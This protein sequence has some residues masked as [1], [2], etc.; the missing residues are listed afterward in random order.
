MTI[1]K[2]QMVANKVDVGIGDISSVMWIGGASML[3]G[4]VLAVMLYGTRD[5]EYE[6]LPIAGANEI[7]EEDV[8]MS[9]DCWKALAAAIVAFVAQLHF[10]S[11][12]IGASC[13]LLVMIL[14][15]AIKWKEID[16]I[17]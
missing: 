9:A 17:R 13:G 15:G 10:E 16:K 11:L 8:K 5:R 4:L 14:T 2:D 7:S 1:I 3:V 6:D 12:P